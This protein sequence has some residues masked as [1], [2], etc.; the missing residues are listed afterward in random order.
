MVGITFTTFKKSEN[1]FILDK[2]HNFKN[3]EITYPKHKLFFTYYDNY[4]YKK[5]EDH[6]YIFFLEGRIYNKSEKEIFNSLSEYLSKYE[7][8]NSFNKLQKWISELDGEYFFSIYNKEK[9]EVIL[10]NDAFARLPVYYYNTHDCF[11]LSRSLKTVLLNIKDKDLTNFGLAEYLLFGYNLDNNT[12]FKSIKHLN[13]RTI[14]KVSKNGKVVFYDSEQLINFQIKSSNNK[15]KNHFSN[16]SDLLKNA[17]ET[18][19]NF[20]SQNIISLSGGLDSRLVAGGLSKA[21]CK[22]IT[23]TLMDPW[24]V[25][26]SEGQLEVD[27]A[28]NISKLIGAYSTVYNGKL[29]RGED[30]LNLLQ[31][32]NGTNHLG[33]SY[34]TRYLQAV[35]DMYGSNITFFT[36]DGGDKVVKYQLPSVNITNDS[37]LISYILKV[38]NRFSLTNVARITNL[39]EEEIINHVI[40]Q[41]KKYPEVDLNYKY[42]KF[43]FNERVKNWLYEGEDRNRNYFWSVTPFYSTEF[44]IESMKTPDIYKKRNRMYIEL[45]NNLNPE[46]TKVTYANLKWPVDSYKSKFYLTLKDFYNSLPG[47]FRKKIKKIIKRENEINETDNFTL[48]V[49]KQQVRTNQKIFENYLNVDEILKFDTLQSDELKMLFNLISTIEYH[50][51]EESTLLNFKSTT[52]P[53]K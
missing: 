15:S 46:L 53:F 41:M 14:I 1:D 6:K 49:L 16:L 31:L 23:T 2:H 42:V 45:L 28:R 7:S 27:I 3:I 11:I 19:L 10:F 51:T 47:E 44:F 29:A 13:P 32:K 4:P 52:F 9:E 21:N 22:I 12:I 39:K 43:V 40:V 35:V 37:Q 8:S 38:H 48:Q 24:K 17:C 5:Y 18:R 34:L 25:D 26:S 50:L 30:L 20:E 36:G 33:F